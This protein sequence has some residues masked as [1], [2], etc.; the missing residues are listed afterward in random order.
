MEQLLQHGFRIGRCLNLLLLHMA[1]LAVCYH[2]GPY[3]G[4]AQID[5]NNV[6]THGF[7]FCAAAAS[8]KTERPGWSRSRVPGICSVGGALRIFATI[9][10]LCAPVASSIRFRASRRLASP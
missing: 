4:A 5:P 3:I 6:S 10:A 9:P 7:R 2:T 1:D 8:R